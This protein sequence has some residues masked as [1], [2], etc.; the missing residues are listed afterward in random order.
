MDRQG[1]A[2]GGWGGGGVET[3]PSN[4]LGQ[5]HNLH[6]PRATLLRE[7]S[8]A[9]TMQTLLEGKL[10]KRTD[11]LVSP[12]S[13]YRKNGITLLNRGFCAGYTLVKKHHGAT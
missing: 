7:T 4:S 1:G 12:L 13:T 2:G 5:H 8:C 9:P 10:E 11:T 6:D 3:A